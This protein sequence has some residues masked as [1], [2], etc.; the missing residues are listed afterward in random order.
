MNASRSSLGST[1]RATFDSSSRSSRSFRCREVRYCPSPVSGESLTVKSMLEVGSST[2]IRGNATGCS[3]SAMVSPMST[4]REPDDGDDVAGLGDLDLG[5]SQLVK[6]HH[7]VDRAI[8]V[9][10]R[11]P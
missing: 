5:S 6:D 4:R 10:G 3:G 11:P 7:A 9:A 1:R 2:S 8:H